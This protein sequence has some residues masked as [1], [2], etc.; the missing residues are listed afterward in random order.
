MAAAHHLL[1]R[2]AVE[3]SET[4]RGARREAIAALVEVEVQQSAQRRPLVHQGGLRPSAL[5]GQAGVHEQHAKVIQAP[6]GSIQKSR[7]SMTTATSVFNGWFDR[8]TTV[9]GLSVHHLHLKTG[10]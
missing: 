3:H 1:E 4:I 5:R 8:P 10:S 2:L 6:L 7:G 9:A